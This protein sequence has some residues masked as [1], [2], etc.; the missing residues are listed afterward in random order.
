MVPVGTK[1]P[2]PGWLSISALIRSAR[3]EANGVKIWPMESV[4]E[5]RHCISPDRRV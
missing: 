3:S 4:K 5:R 1:L 2:T